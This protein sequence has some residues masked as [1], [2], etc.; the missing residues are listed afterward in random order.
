[1]LFSCFR[2]G[3]SIEA[4]HPQSRS[5]CTVQYVQSLLLA[6]LQEWFLLWGCFCSSRFVELEITTVIQF[7]H[8]IT[9]IHTCPN[10]YQGSLLFKTL[11]S[12]FNSCL[13]LIKSYIS[14][15]KTN[16]QIFKIIL[17]T[18]LTE[19]IKL[20][21]NLKDLCNQFVETSI[22]WTFFE[23]SRQS[24]ALKLHDSYCGCFHF[25]I[26]IEKWCNLFSR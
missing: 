13:Y 17:S 4:W 14:Q 16:N 21:V 5:T 12:Y 18:L 20:M 11:I 10:T 24:F 6:S 25:M 2:C 26:F 8:C 23:T 22:R 19:K 3:T 15:Q 9:F 1:M 7:T